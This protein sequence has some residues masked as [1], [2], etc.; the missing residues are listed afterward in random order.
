M[1]FVHRCVPVDEL[2]AQV[3]AMAATILAQSLIVT[4]LTKR[5]IR[6]GR[7]LPL[8][9]AVEECER[10]YLDELTGTEDMVEGLDAFLEKRKPQW[11]HR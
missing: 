5:A 1:G 9:Q 4:R 2:E 3:E 11:K 10:I 6:A 7:R 8:A